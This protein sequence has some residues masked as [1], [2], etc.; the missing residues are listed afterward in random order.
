MKLNE[1]LKLI[2]S[3]EKIG[4]SFSESE[5]HKNWSA[6]STILNQ[7]KIEKYSTW[8]VTGKIAPE[9]GQISPAIAH[10]GRLT[11]ILLF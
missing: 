3:V 6:I 10:N 7:K 9:A 11:T 8:F 4:L 1:K 5:E 2:E